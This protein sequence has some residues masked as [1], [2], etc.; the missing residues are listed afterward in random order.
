[1]VVT[2]DG[3]S[4]LVKAEQ[5]AKAQRSIVVTLD[6]ISMSVNAVQL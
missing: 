3:I 5:D 6:V 2:P 1:M 4:I